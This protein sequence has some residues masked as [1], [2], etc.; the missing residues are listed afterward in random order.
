LKGKEEYSAKETKQ[1]ENLT[2]DEAA[3]L[4]KEDIRKKIYLAK[5]HEIEK[6]QKARDAK[7]SEKR[8]SENI[9]DLAREEGRKEIFLAQEKKLAEGHEARRLKDN[10]YYS[11]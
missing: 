7:Q 3:R 4:A 8:V 9:K 10:K 11:K 5:E 2:A 1:I 6:A